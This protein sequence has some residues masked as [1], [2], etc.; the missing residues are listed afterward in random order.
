M[1]IPKKSVPLCMCLQ[2]LLKEESAKKDLL[3]PR[4][5]INTCEAFCKQTNTSSS[6]LC[7][8]GEPE[9]LTMR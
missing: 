2:V 1:H 8:T 4:S 7:I 3:P 9:S 6:L 5:L